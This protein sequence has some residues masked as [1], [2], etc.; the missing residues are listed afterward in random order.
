MINL[1]STPQQPWYFDVQILQ[2]I[3][4][5]H[6]AQKPKTTNHEPPND[7]GRAS[8][9]ASRKIGIAKAHSE[10][11]QSRSLANERSIAKLSLGR[12]LEKIEGTYG[13][14]GRGH[15]YIIYYRYIYIYI[16]NIYA[17]AHMRNRNGLETRTSL[18]IQY[19]RLSESCKVDQVYKNLSASSAL[20]D[21]GVCTPGYSKRTSS[22]ESVWPKR[23]QTPT[24]HLWPGWPKPSAT[25][26]VKQL[27]RIE[28]T[29]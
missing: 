20:Q 15:I 21:P 5:S 16:S 9:K 27:F 29:W 23:C 6:Q 28:D 26:A 25:M 18:K 2:I 8:Q 11:H 4:T 12:G 13:L 17:Y 19:I 14:E 7:Q 3:F 1:L 10:V 24:V 22:S